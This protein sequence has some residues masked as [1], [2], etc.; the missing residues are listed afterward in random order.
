MIGG[1]LPVQAAFV[2]WLFATGAWPQFV[3]GVFG[4]NSMS[5]RLLEVDTF[6]DALLVPIWALDVAG[7]AFWIAGFAG[8]VLALRTIREPGPVQFLR[9][10][11]A[12]A[13][14]RSPSWK[15][16]TTITSRTCIY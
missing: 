15:C 12:P 3:E 10:W 4:Y 16:S 2:G 9:F 14:S 7:I 13:W 1:V 8:A 5:A 11:S 6:F